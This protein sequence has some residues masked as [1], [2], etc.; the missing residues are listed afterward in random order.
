MPT[1][2][3]ST[4]ID[5]CDAANTLQHFLQQIEVH[6]RDLCVDY[7]DCLNVNS[8]SETEQYDFAAARVKADLLHTQA[9]TALNKAHQLICLS[10]VTP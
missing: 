9:V 10:H 5:I 2:K 3:Q 1:S 7:F 6:A 4:L 8:L